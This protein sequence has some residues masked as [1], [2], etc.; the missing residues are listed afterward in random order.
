MEFLSSV[1]GVMVLALGSVLAIVFSTAAGPAAVF[2]VMLLILFGLG[3]MMLHG[4][5]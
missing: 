4:F 5:F 2:R 1:P 3:A